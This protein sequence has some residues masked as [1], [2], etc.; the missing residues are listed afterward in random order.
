M[1]PRGWWGDTGLPLDGSGA[2][3]AAERIAVAIARDQVEGLRGVVRVRSWLPHVVSEKNVI[4]RNDRVGH[5]VYIITY[6]TNA[7]LRK[8]KWRKELHVT[9]M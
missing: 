6:K 4:G 3:G 7:P 9:Y 8:S 1:R 5:A 2:G